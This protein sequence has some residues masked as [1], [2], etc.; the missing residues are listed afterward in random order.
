MISE[1]A[2]NPFLYLDWIYKYSNVCATIRLA[3]NAA[4]DILEKNV[5]TDLD[6]LRKDIEKMPLNF[7]YYLLCTE[8]KGRKLSFGEIE[9]NVKTVLMAVR[10]RFLLKMLKK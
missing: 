1:R 10:S 8:I 4:H 9:D 2:T 3:H 6:I 7:L 5:G